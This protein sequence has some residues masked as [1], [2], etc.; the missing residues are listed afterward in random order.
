MRTVHSDGAG[1]LRGP[2]AASGSPVS[3]RRPG[4]R[5]RVDQLDRARVLAGLSEREL[6]RKSCVDRKTIADALC[7]RRRPT[8]GSIR[9][10]CRALGLT[11]ADVIE[12]D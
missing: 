1:G 11:L 5:L 10:I 6:A 9:A 4:W 8:L 3:D 12:F 2:R 7:R